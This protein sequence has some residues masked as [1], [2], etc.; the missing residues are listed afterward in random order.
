MRQVWLAGPLALAAFLLLGS[1]W[2]LAL[3]VNG[4]YDEKQHVVRAYAAVTGQWLPTGHAPDAIGL[5]N[6]AFDAP[7]S[8]LPELAD[9]TWSPRPP[10]PASCQIEVTDRAH[11]A[12]PSGAARYSPV[13]Y[14]LVGAPLLISPD[15]TGVILARLLS[16]LFAAA[17]FA[18][19]FMIAARLGNR[20]LSLAIVLAATPLVIN[21]GASVNPN[22]VEMSAGVLLFTALLGLVRTDPAEQPGRW[23]LVAIGGSGA[24]LITVR[25]LGPVLCLAALLAV[26]V[27]A[28]RERLAALLRSARTWALAGAPML[29]AVLFAAWWTVYSKVTDA[30]EVPSRALPYSAGEIVRR[31]PGERGRF[32]LDQV[33]ARFSYG[34]TLVSPAMIYAW[35]LA[36]ALLVLPALWYGTARLRLATAGVL[37]V[38]AAILIG[39]ELKFVPTAGWWAQPRYVMPLGLGV[40]VLAAFEGRLAS[41]FAGPLP[42][43]LESRLPSRL[44][45]HGYPGLP[46]VAL[47][48]ALLP[49]HLYALA[50]VLARFESGI[51]AG[52]NPFVD[53]SW[54]PAL[55]PWPPVVTMVLG[56]LTLLAAVMVTALADRTPVAQAAPGAQRAQ[57]QTEDDLPTGGTTLRSQVSAS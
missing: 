3:P 48:A 40:L 41:R 4:T 9:C 13:Y 19:A 6:E 12:M 34:E 25:G 36:M 7:R 28:T 2:A 23:L 31:I 56:C 52:P 45:G 14:L 35:Y 15:Q 53:G 11:T 55:G 47:V 57:A 10:K 44:R 26:A 22:G 38:C 30:A 37:T 50:R 1:A 20:L 42:G 49:L 54:Q 51:A 21:I 43:W 16:A 46:V 17:M 29:V 8:L 33:V 5:P 18:A 24:L 32:Y 39:L 27:V